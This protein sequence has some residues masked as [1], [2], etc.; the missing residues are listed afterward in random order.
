MLQVHKPYNT[1]LLLINLMY[2]ISN[3]ENPHQDS[4]TLYVVEFY[5]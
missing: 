3:N 2:Y 5:E 1:V 4:C